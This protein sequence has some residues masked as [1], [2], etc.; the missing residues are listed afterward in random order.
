MLA[1]QSAHAGHW[2][3]EALNHFDAM[4]SVMPLSA[5]D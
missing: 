5:R 4:G 2:T 3:K 1:G